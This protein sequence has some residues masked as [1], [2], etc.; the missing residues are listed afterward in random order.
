MV[1]MYTD[2]AVIMPPG[3]P[4]VV[5]KDATRDFFTAQFT[6]DVVTTEQV[7]TSILTE[8]EGNQAFDRGTFSWKGTRPGASDTVTEVGRPHRLGR[9]RT[10]NPRF[11]SSVVF[12]PSGSVLSRLVPSYTDLATPSSRLVPSSTV[13]SLPVGLQMVCSHPMDGPDRSVPRSGAE[14]RR[15][16]S[17]PGS[18]TTRC[19]GVF[20]GYDH[21]L[22]HFAETFWI[23]DPPNGA[24]G[25]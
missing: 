5:G 23:E 7:F 4:V 12:V 16:S 1:A 22:L 13:L 8:G 11:W 19:T 6:S 21:S 18:S 15:R 20:G 25:E 17:S 2:D 24:R 3:A 9:T 14:C 10:C